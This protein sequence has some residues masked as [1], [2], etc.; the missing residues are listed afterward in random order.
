YYNYFHMRKKQFELLEQMLA[1]V[2]KLPKQDVICEPIASFFEKLADSVH[3]G[4]TAILFLDE[5]KELHK[6]IKSEELPTTQDQF[7]TRSNLF[8]L[9]QEIE[10]YLIIKNRFKSSDVKRG[11]K[12][13]KKRKST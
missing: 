4:N 12:P 5:I 6:M 10:D 9:L 1:L 7:E 8:Q 13:L 2:V 3:P 11:K